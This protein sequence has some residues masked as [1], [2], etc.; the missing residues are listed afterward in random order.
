MTETLYSK[1]KKRQSTPRRYLWERG[2]RVERRKR[3]E[4]AN[5]IHRSPSSLR[6][7]PS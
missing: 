1:F 3:E 2:T 7:S 5:D 6:S 4:D